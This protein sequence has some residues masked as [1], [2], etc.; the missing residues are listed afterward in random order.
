MNRDEI[1]QLLRRWQSGDEGAEELLLS[2]VYGELRRIAGTHMRRERPEHTLQATAVVHET[3]LRL[4]RHD[5]L[6]FRDRRHFFNF[7]SR[8]MRRLLMDHGRTRLAA[9]RGGGLAWAPFSEAMAKTAE[10]RRRPLAFDLALQRLGGQDPDLARVVRLRVLGGLTL[11]ETA[12][13]LGC[14]VPT[15]TRRWVTARAWLEREGFAA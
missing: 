15:A 4:I 5:R 10:D 6:E 1:T 8:L 7:A 3:Y 2:R 14:S 11:R 13:A 12:S 9:K